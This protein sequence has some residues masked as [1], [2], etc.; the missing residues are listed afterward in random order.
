MPHRLLDFNPY[1]VTPVAVAFVFTPPK[2]LVV[3]P[4]PVVRMDREPEAG[5]KVMPPGV[6]AIAFGIA[7]DFC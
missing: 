2:L 1:A 7:D 5:M 6:P 4:F 3:G